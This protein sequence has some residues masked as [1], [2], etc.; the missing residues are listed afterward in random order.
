MSIASNPFSTR[1]VKPGV[2]PFL[3]LEA[4][5]ILEMARKLIDSHAMVQIVGPHGAGKTTLTFAIEKQLNHL[6]LAAGQKLFVRRLTVGAGQSV[7]SIHGTVPTG[8]DRNGDPSLLFVV[9]G[10]ERMGFLQQLGFLSHCRK[11]GYRLLATTHRP[12][13]KLPVIHR[14]DS[15]ADTLV[16]LVSH[17]SPDLLGQAGF[18]K[19]DL[20]CLFI[21]QKGDLR[22]CLMQLYDRFEGQSRPR[23]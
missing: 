6:A 1:N 13:K 5:R 20:E 12:L 4:S 8:D 15:K 18:R 11:N 16:K 22:E 10:I 2:I 23:I 7:R 21:E 14:I 3:G 17:L 19:L 9:D